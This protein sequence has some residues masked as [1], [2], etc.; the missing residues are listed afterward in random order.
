MFLPECVEEAVDV[1]GVPLVG[2]GLQ[3]CEEGRPVQLWVGV[4]VGVVVT[5]FFI[6]FHH[7]GGGRIFPIY[8]LLPSMTFL[9]EVVV[10]EE[11]DRVQLIARRGRWYVTLQRTK[12]KQQVVIRGFLGAVPWSSSGRLVDCFS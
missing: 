2:W 3:R 7:L 8:Y 4:G 10:V 6:S 9:P 1:V 11:V 5:V 12:S